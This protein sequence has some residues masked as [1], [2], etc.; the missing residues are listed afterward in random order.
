MES[1][2]LPRSSSPRRSALLGCVASL[3]ISACALESPIIVLPPALRDQSDVLPVSGR[4]GLLSWNRDIRFGPYRTTGTRVGWRGDDSTSWGVLDANYT[5]DSNRPVSFA[6]E[7]ATCQ[8]WRARCL[9]K[10]HRRH[11]EKAVGLEASGHG[12]AIDRRVVED[13]SAHGFECTLQ[14]G[15]ASAW[16]LVLSADNP[17][18]FGGVLMDDRGSTV[19]RIRAT[20]RQTGRPYTYSVPSPVGFIIEASSADVAA[21]ER[22]FD[23][24]VILA[25]STPPTQRCA[26]ATVAA[27][28]LLWEPLR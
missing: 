10:A 27:A 22:A 6:L 26:L 4:Q 18:G 28:L 24:K 13:T 1:R 23:G 8:R 25:R 9:G 19:A 21:V 14:P 17:S 5:W 7:A 15:D 16:Q 12:L 2:R 20:D 3:T 11:R